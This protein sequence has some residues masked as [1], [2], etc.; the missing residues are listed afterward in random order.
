MKP[1]SD[2]T[3][4]FDA[5]SREVAANQRGAAD[6][7]RKRCVAVSL[8]GGNFQKIIKIKLIARQKS[9]FRDLSRP[10]RRSVFR[11]GSY[12]LPRNQALAQVLCNL[13]LKR[14]FSLHPAFARH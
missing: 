8:K 12:A 6:N 11:P 3:I 10:C 14:V 5:L 9:G 4:P 7:K 13:Q 2:G 1:L